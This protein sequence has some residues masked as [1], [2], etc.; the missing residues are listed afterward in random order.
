MAS[1]T[2]AVVAGAPVASTFVVSCHAHLGL[3]WNH[4]TNGSDGDCMGK[5][6]DAVGIDVSC[7]SSMRALGPDLTGGNAEVARTV[8]AAP[9]RYV[10][11]VVFNPHFPAESL[12][13]VERYFATGDFGMIKV[14]PEFHAYPM[15]GPGYRDMYRLASDRHVPVLTHSWGHGRGYD[16]PDL[17]YHLGAEF[18]ELRLVLAHAGG[19]PDGLRA[20]IAVAQRFPHVYLDTA[21]SLVYRGSI[22]FL[23]EHVG[24]ERIVFGTDAVYIADAPQLARVVGSDITDA[25]QRM[26]LGGNLVGL[27]S[28]PRIGL[29]RDWAR[30]DA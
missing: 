28:D 9:D 23:V 13:E 20:S 29:D 4:P 3:G 30:A 18:P 26:I 22:E 11:T 8:R 25:A 16:H 19:T 15:D 27:L 24:P 17:A 1:L 7:V 21:T 2:D 10:G 12:A 6:M 14:H 5:T